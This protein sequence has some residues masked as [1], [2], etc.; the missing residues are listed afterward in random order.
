MATRRNSYVYGT[1]APKY[2]IPARIQDDA[3]VRRLSNEARRNRE[4]AARMNLGYVAFLLGALLLTS[5]VLI[6]YIRIQFDN[7]TMVKQISALESQLNQMKLENEEEY[8]RIMSSVDLDE[9][10]RVAIE[11]LGMQYAQEGQVI[12]VEDSKDDYVHQYQDMP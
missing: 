12:Q 10:R 7:V 11:E 8:S 4:R 2:D 9:V 6:S 5:V 1:A 3:P